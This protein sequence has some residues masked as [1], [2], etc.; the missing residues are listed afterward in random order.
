M[1]SAGKA[2]G[3]GVQDQAPPVIVA[4]V[5]P[6]V[7]SEQFPAGQTAGQEVVVATGVLGEEEQFM[8]TAKEALEDGAHEQAPSR[9]IVAGVPARG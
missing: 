9:A 5:S 4:G 8:E 2:P 7:D 3:N 6:E 1:A